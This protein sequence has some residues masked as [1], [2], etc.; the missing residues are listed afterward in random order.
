MSHSKISFTHRER[1][2]YYTVE[3]YGWKR[4]RPRPD[5]FWQYVRR[6][7]RMQSSHYRPDR[8]RLRYA[9]GR[10]R[11]ALAPFKCEPI[12]LISS[13]WRLK[14]D[15]GAGYFY[16]HES[17]DFVRKFKTKNEVEFFDVK[18]EVRRWKRYGR[19]DNPSAIA[20]RSHLARGKEHKSRVVYVTPYPVCCLEG[21]Y[22][23]P[24][25]EQ[26]KRSS[27]S[28]PFGTQH[29]WLNG[30]FRK[31]KSSHKGYPTS[32][33][34]SGFD[35]SVKRFFIE[36]A[37]D[38]LREVY[39]L[40]T[41]EEQEWQL[42][43]EYFINT[44]V[45]VGGKDLVLEGG[46]PSGSVWTHIVGSTISMLIA[47]YCVPDLLSV[48]CFGDDLVIFTKDPLSLSLVVDLAK[49][50]GFE[51][52]MGKSVCGAIHWL[53][54][55]ITG[56]IPRVLNPV[57]RWAAFFHPDRPDESMAHH[58]GRLIGYALSS[59]GDPAFMNDFMIL[60][61]ELQGPA[62]MTDSCL[63]PEFRGQV[64]HDLQTLRKV[65]RNVL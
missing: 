5:E 23:I 4:C 54:F 45:R 42:F 11:Q 53:G 40:R 6:H 25:L 65:F 57:K 43:V 49:T 13:F 50:L 16:C 18:R 20:F 46:I 14:K 7:N 56:S 60:W 26:M 27:Y 17:E 51:I 36:I 39:S 1:E 61:E 29:N 55:D 28:S 22:A 48:K 15:T 59:L 52:S 3:S 62:I 32:I 30:G 63:A 41:S 31:F 24:L 19:I 47:Y 21:R 12:S 37:F 34:F 58:R 64:V 2:L 9:I 44:V 8:N 10:V 35:L 38:L 33:D